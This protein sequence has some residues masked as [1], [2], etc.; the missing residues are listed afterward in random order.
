MIPK[1]IVKQV[2]VQN[3]ITRIKAAS[4]VGVHPHR[5]QLFEQKDCMPS[6]IFATFLMQRGI[7]G[8][9]EWIR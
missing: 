5:W 2:R 9:Q 1:E 7:E 8:Y 3:G 4:V 6:T